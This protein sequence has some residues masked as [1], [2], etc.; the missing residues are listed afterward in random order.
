M[1]QTNLNPLLVIGVFL[2]LLAIVVIN[3][4]SITALYYKWRFGAVVDVLPSAP[5]FTEADRVLI[6]SPHPDDESL[7][8]G[9][10]IQQALEANAQVFVVWL[11]SGDA[12]ELDG[13]LTQ[14]TLRPRGSPMERLGEKRIAEAKNAAKVLGLRDDRLFI[15]G[16]PDGGLEKLLYE[17][18]SLPYRSR[19]TGLDGV[20]YAGAVSPGAAYT[21]E[22]LLRDLRFV[23]QQAGPTVVLAPSPLDRHA[24]HRAA[25][26]LTLRILGETDEVAKGRWWIVHGGVEWP[27]PKNLRP[28]LPLYPPPAGRGMDW[29]SVAI[30][31]EQGDVKLKAINAHRSQF[32]I[33]AR[34]L[35][36][37][38]RRNELVSSGP[39][40]VLDAEDV[41]AP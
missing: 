10:M 25:G 1:P 9:G 34:F 37:F 21:G 17:H 20:S 8:C 16:Y 35:E 6:I 18:F 3:A 2:A 29:Q 15:L 33:Q 41:E 26:N 19:Y 7:C 24:D 12:F 31:P 23:F 27:L 40:P 13:V 14:R 28:R 22:N 36:A 39:L 5:G 32:P 11:T 4:P 38:V 30:T